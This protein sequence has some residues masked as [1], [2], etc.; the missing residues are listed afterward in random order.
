[1][2]LEGLSVIS[3]VGLG[4]C[5]GLSFGLKAQINVPVSNI[6]TSVS[7]SPSACVSTD[8]TTINNMLYAETVTLIAVL[9]V[10]GSVVS[11]GKGWWKSF[12]MSF[13]LI[14]P[15]IASLILGISWGYLQFVDN[16]KLY[17]QI[18]LGCLVG[19]ILLSFLL[20]SFLRNEKPGIVYLLMIIGLLFCAVGGLFAGS[21]NDIEGNPNIGNDAQAGY[22]TLWILSIVSGGIAFFGGL[23]YWVKNRNP[24]EQPAAESPAAESPTESPY[25]KL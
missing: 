16:H 6:S 5:M 15:A 11:G 22:K 10:V 7:N 20:I 2:I 17:Y 8:Q 24:K 3:L 12:K 1:M 19:I 14:L 4:A 21:N 18:G 13:Y 25:D 9:L 23:A